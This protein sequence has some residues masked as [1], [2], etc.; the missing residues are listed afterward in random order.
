MWLAKMRRACKFGVYQAYQRLYVGVFAHQTST[1]TRDGFAGRIVLDLC[2][3]RPGS[4]YDVTLPLRESA[5][6]Y[7]KTQRGAIRIRVHLEYKNEQ[8]AVLSYLPSS[9]PKLPKFQPHDQITV[10]CTDVKAFQNVARAVHGNDMPGRFS[11]TL[12]KATLREVNYQRIL[13]TRH[14]RKREIR[15]TMFWKTPVLSAFLFTSWMHS[16][17]IGSVRYIPGHVITF[18]LLHMLKNYGRYHIDGKYDNGFLAPTWEEL[19]MALWKGG[20]ASST[21]QSSKQYYIQPLEM[22]RKEADTVRSAG[23]FFGNAGGG[24]HHH[25]PTLIDM[26][27]DLQE[28]I[29]LVQNKWYYV[30]TYKDA[31]VAKKAVSFLVEQGYAKNRK[32]AVQIG[33][34]MQNK[35]KLF[36]HIHRSKSFSDSDD[37]FRFLDFDRSNFIMRTHKAMGKG[38]FFLTILSKPFSSAGTRSKI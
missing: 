14:L 35:L 13:L 37:I 16:V 11:M 20:K 32:E 1:T 10:E 29:P 3:L 7:Q 6:V 27:N 28:N 31:F 5:H 23:E 15:D 19:F 9:L 36:D 24:H 18:L 12:V 33:L 21:G 26:C 22:Q 8:K 2:R 25:Q 30:R 34:K 38:E 17:W 4:L